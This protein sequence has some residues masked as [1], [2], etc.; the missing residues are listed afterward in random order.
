MSPRGPPHCTPTRGGPSAGRCRRGGH[1][2]RSGAARGRQEA[3]RRPVARLAPIKSRTVSSWRPARAGCSVAVRR[4]VSAARPA[5]P[6]SPAEMSRR[7]R[8]V[9]PHEWNR[10]TPAAP[11]APSRADPRGSTDHGATRP[12]TLGDG[13]ALA[14]TRGALA[15]DPATH[16]AG[17]L[18]ARGVCA[19]CSREPLLPMT[20]A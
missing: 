17:W 7:D 13:A 1:P 3:R 15:Q 16:V 8:Q 6:A 14:R 19:C 2:P 10:C 11:A 4:T 20:P 18:L 12:P 9:E 5:R